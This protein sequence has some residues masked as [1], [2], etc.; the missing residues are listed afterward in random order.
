MEA[1][2]NYAL[3]LNDWTFKGTLPKDE[4]R[5]GQSIHLLIE[6]GRQFLNG[7]VACTERY[8][9]L[10]R[11]EYFDSIVFDYSVSFPNFQSI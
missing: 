10:L 2:I 11:M 1:G 6:A 7:S 3:A 9:P 4:H 5:G 8:F